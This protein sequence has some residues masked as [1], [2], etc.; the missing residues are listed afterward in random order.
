MISNYSECGSILVVEIVILAVVLAV[1]GTIGY[2]AVS[3]HRKTPIMVA[4]PLTATP[5]TPQPQSA[6]PVPGT[7]VTVTEADN[8]KTIKLNKLQSLT[9]KLSSTYWQIEGSSDANII[10]MV[11]S[12]IYR[13]VTGGIPG[14]GT[15]TAV[16]SPGAPGIATISASRTSCGEALQCTESQ[17]KFHINITVVTPDLK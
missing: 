12:P 1:A 2:K 6:A 5:P 13:P 3:L 15:V 4:P 14:T 10:H 7:E 11:E 16:F 8:G 9:L 17:G